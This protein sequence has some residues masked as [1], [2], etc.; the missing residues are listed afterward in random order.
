MAIG[1]ITLAGG[2]RGTLS[3]LQLT[4]ALLAQTTERLATG[5]RVNSSVDDPVAYFAAQGH[6]SRASQLDARKLAIGE[7]IQTVSA[8]DAGVTAITGLIE[9]AR[10]IADAARSAASG[11]LTTL[12][13]QYDT[14]STQIDQLA[15]DAGYKG[16]NLLGAG[17]SLVVS[18]NEDASSTL[19]ITGF[20]ATTTGLSISAADFSSSATIDAAV[21]ELDT[22]QSTLRTNAQALAAN[23]SVLTTRQEFLTSLVGTLQ[24]GAD[25][26]VVADP[27]EESANL[28]ALQ[29]RQQLGIVALGLSTQVEQSILRLF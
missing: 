28:L 16:V 21:A 27:N 20:D 19:T 11:D 23:A 2:L 8:A 9:Q 12:E 22:A 15:G 7:A 4:S 3:R 25:Q 18:F 26:L 10:G 6:R 13:A 5:R 1:D 17:S 24:E 14:I 29:T